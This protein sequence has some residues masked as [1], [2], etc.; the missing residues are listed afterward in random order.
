MNILLKSRIFLIFF[1]IS[2]AFTQD[3]EK[4]DMI[5]TP[6]SHASFVI[7]TS[8]KTIF[9]DPVGNIND[10]STFSPP[11]IILITHAHG[12]HLSKEI[13]DAVK[14]EKTVIVGPKAVVDQLQ[15][16]EIL[17]NGDKKIFAGVLIE[18]I[19]MYNLTE[20]RLNFHKKGQGNGYVVTLKEKRIYISGD[21]E[22]IVEMR[23][24]TAI[25]YAFICMNLPYTMTV[26]QAAS[27]VLEMK[28]KVVFPYH[29]RGTDGFSDI[30]K[31]KELV[32]ENSDIEVRFLKWY[33]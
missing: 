25:D 9:V 18:A 3:L 4:N 33:N 26:E 13:V 8:E 17:N 12:D 20:D 32:G 1:L 24:L 16:G 31:F 19:P 5:F 15:Y 10:Y 28:P 2:S 6:I 14:E 7:Q 21:T 30:E 11:D 29:Y 23:R 27:A 22:D